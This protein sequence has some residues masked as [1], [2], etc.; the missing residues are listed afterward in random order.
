MLEKEEIE[1]KTERLV[2]LL[3]TEKLGSL[4]LTSQPNFAWLSAGRR[5]G[6]DLSR[7]NGSCAL[8]V[9]ENG[10]RYVMANNIEM[11]RL[12]DEELTAENFEPIEFAWEE[13]KESPFFFT[14]LA[15]RLTA[16]NMEVGSDLFLDT[17]SRV[18]ESAVA[19]CR[20]RLTVSEVERYRQLGNDAGTAISKLGR[21][22]KQGLS[23]KEIARQVAAALAVYD[24][25]T[26][27]TLVAA[28]ERTG[29]FR[30]PIPTER[31]W[32]KVLMIVVCARRYGLTV[33]FT[34]I[35]CAGKVP[36][37][38]QRRTNA[39]AYVNAKLFEATKSGTNGSELYNVARKAYTEM[40]FDGEEKRHHQGGST[41][42][43]T[44]DWIA[45]P[46]CS[47]TVQNSQAFAWNPSITGTKTEETCLLVNDCLETI[48]SSPEWQNITINLGD[49]SYS[50]PDI[51]EI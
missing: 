36:I 42:Y 35:V 5:S 18:V 25:H 1:E 32:E 23:E 31:V 21:S 46:L 8:L 39:C 15:K 38:L 3:K 20:H 47:E 26:V 48:T 4:L 24:I 50:F 10:Q 27:V 28:D 41:G 30:H 29:K 40:G 7:E 17:N 12:L 2:R 49:Q 22:L 34:R 6:V 11:P 44:R 43:K 14:D 51:L 33:S 37:E 9:L 45:H 19:R 16:K 13:E